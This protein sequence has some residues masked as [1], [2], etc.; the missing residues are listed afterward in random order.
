[1]MDT[2]RGVIL[3]GSNIIKKIFKKERDRQENQ[4]SEDGAEARMMWS[5]ESRTVASSRR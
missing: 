3:D 4:R 1:M 2:K 5:H